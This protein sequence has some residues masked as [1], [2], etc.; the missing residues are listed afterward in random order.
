MEDEPIGFV[1]LGE[2]QIG[3]TR[4]NTRL[5]RFI[6][7]KAMYDHVRIETDTKVMC[8]FRSLMS[9]QGQFDN[10]AS[11][12]ETFHFPR[13]VDECVVETQVLALF[14]MAMENAVKVEDDYIPEDW[15]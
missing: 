10:L 6:A 4:S 12:I 1:N 8:M 15:L 7:E 11:H 5:V 14:H 13:T 2:S 9:E 3:L